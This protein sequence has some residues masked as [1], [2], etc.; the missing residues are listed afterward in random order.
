MFKDL[1]HLK[2][3]FD[4]HKLSGGDAFESIQPYKAYIQF[5]DKKEIKGNVDRIGMNY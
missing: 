2:H 3:I 1:Y 5:G 4:D